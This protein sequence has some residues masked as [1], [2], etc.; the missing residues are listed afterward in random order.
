M[1]AI[2][3]GTRNPIVLRVIGLVV[4]LVLGLVYWDGRFGQSNGLT[5]R[6]QSS[7]PNGKSSTCV[8]D[9]QLRAVAIPPKRRNAIAALGDAEHR[10]SQHNRA[11]SARRSARA[12]LRFQQ[13][14]DAQQLPSRPPGSAEAAPEA[15]K[16]ALPILLVALCL[17]VLVLAA[18]LAYMFF[19]RETPGRSRP[20]G[21]TGRNRRNQTPNGLY[22]LCYRRNRTTDR[23]V[24]GIL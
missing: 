9:F 1:D 21:Y 13:R 11:G 2:R 5:P 19:F 15:K 6:R 3:E 10:R 14:G 17:L 24:H 12:A 16:S 23:A 4:G 20:T 7:A 22:R 18:F 8:A